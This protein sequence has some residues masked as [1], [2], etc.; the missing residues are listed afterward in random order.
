LGAH[1]ADDKR[2]QLRQLAGGIL[3]RAQED[4]SFANQLRTDPRATL[5]AAGLPE[6]AVDDFITE[7]QLDSDVSGYMFCGG[8]GCTNWSTCLESDWDTACGVS[9]P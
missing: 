5:I 6:S 2:T 1:N 8:G 7:M 9:V 3:Q 4:D